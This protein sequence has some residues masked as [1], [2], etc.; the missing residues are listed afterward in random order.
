MLWVN[1]TSRR[2]RVAKVKPRGKLLRNVEEKDYDSKEFGGGRMAKKAV[3]LT[4]Q[5]IL[6]HGKPTLLRVGSVQWFRLPKLDRLDLLQRFKAAGFNTVDM[7]VPWRDVEPNGEGKFDEG[8]LEDMCDFLGKCKNVGLYVYFRPGPYICDEF[9]GGGVPS[10]LLKKTRTRDDDGDNT[11]AIIRTACP[12]WLGHVRRYFNKINIRILPYLASKGGPIVLYAIENEYDHFEKAFAAE[13]I[14]FSEGK[15]ER[16][17]FQS[18]GTKAYFSALRDITRRHIDVPIAT[19]PGM[20]TV[21]GLGDVEGIW[22]VPNHWDP[23][24][25]EA[26]ALALL[27]SMR[28]GHGGAYKDMPLGFSE[29]PSI[30]ASQKRQILSGI[31]MSA[32]FNA[33]GHHQFGYRN[34][35]DF[36]P[37]NIGVTMG[38]MSHIAPQNGSMFSWR[39][40]RMSN[41]LLHP[42]VGYLGS[43]LDF[44]G[45]VSHSG[46]IREKFYSFRRTGYMCNTFERSIARAYS[47]TSHVRPR[48]WSLFPRIECCR[49]V[50]MEVTLRDD[51][52]AA[53][54]K[55][56]RKFVTWLECE[57]GAMFVSILNQSGVP[58]TLKPG[59][60][61]IDD[62]PI[63]KYTNLTV[64]TEIYPG[65]RNDFEQLAYCM[66]LPV[67][68]PITN[69][70]K[71]RYTT[72]EILTKKTISEQ[73]GIRGE[74]ASTIVILYGPE[75]GQGEAVFDICANIVDIS[76]I[77]D[78]IRRHGNS[79]S[80]VA[81]SFRYEH[82]PRF[83]TL[84]TDSGDTLQVMVTTSRLAGRVW[85]LPNSVFLVG[86]DYV[87]SIEGKERGVKFRYEHDARVTTA[88][89][90]LLSAKPCVLE[91][92]DEVE[93]YNPKTGVTRFIKR[94]PGILPEVRRDLLSTCQVYRD[95][96]ESS[97]SFD[98]TSW[99]SF[100]G[101]PLSLDE[102]DIHEGHAWYRA[103]I[104][105]TKG[106]IETLTPRLRIDHAD[107]FV[108]IYVNG[109]YITTL[110]PLGNGIDTNE[111]D[112][113]G[114]SERILRSLRAGRNVLTFLIEIWGHGAFE[115]PTGGL[116]NSRISLPA[117]SPRGLKGLH[118]KVILGDNLRLSKWKV[119]AR[120]SGEISTLN[121]DSRRLE[122]R[123]E[124][125][126]KKATKVH[127]SRGEVIWCT[128]TF[129]NTDLPGRKEYHAPFVLRIKGKNARGTVFLNNHPQPIGR[130]I[131]DDAWLHRG[132]WANPTREMWSYANPDDVPI[133]IR[134]LDE[135]IN[136][137]RIALIDCSGSQVSEPTDVSESKR[138]ERAIEIELALNNDDLAVGNDGKTVRA[139]HAAV[140]GE[141]R[142]SVVDVKVDEKT[143]EMKVVF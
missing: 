35:I 78:T 109:S 71:L 42:H 120:L 29:G 116:L 72:A 125:G 132:T 66:I 74:W 126:T 8:F 26:D 38:G 113:K 56:G 90:T 99:R 108:G 55:S 100:T 111:E 34:A 21:S 57:N 60:I 115:T 121:N 5:S 92:F 32:N 68:L 139:P 44:Y 11:K 93:R 140:R 91:G 12:L 33:V 83:L 94:F 46:S 136:T 89:V 49:G 141:G 122:P 118:G 95:M 97:P 127:L 28:K 84:R 129:S 79:S 135:K 110:A 41:L 36:D 104:N 40:G 67:R 48:T 16:R 81:I 30:A 98:D 47:R 59:A 61:S 112:C 69:T 106:E 14:F 52:V 65:S 45:P 31:R 51:R 80:E 27:K 142:A 128:A 130:W 114:S 134:S 25:H 43:V 58:I 96:K 123:S 102:L 82:Q 105:L 124:S 70:Y 3:Q 117:L 1:P 23:D 138:S 143:Q 73:L 75:G 62:T 9:D 7:Y 13:K 10:W 24:G 20:P 37:K 107:D 19:C 17:L 101:N 131:S 86:L 15:A 54:D 4:K 85:E 137:L 64:P 63:P 87:Q 103:E 50:Q 119:R 6:I 88:D 133:P 39:R 76:H 2:K 53:K 22:P 77:D 18:T